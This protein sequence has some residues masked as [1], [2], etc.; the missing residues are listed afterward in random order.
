VKQVGAVGTKRL[1]SVTQPPPHPRF[2]ARLGY[3]SAGCF[4]AEPA[5]ASP[6]TRQNA[7]RAGAKQIWG[8]GVGGRSEEQGTRNTERG[9]RQPGFRFRQRDVHRKTSHSPGLGL[10]LS[11]NFPSS[12][13]MDLIATAAGRFMPNTSTV[14]L[15]Q[16]DR[17]TTHHS[18]VHEK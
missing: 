8:E 17:P 9:A 18:K 16:G 3:S 13:S 12:A 7:T 1:V 4:P 2:D 5:S 15:P 11:G 14:P 6:S 10:D